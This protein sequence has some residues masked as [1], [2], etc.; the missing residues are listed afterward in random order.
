[1]G[2]ETPK[3]NFAKLT[4]TYP[5]EVS[6]VREE[7]EFKGYTV[8][9]REENGWGDPILTLNGA[10]FRYNKEKKQIQVF[11]VDDR[12]V[13]CDHARAR[14]AML[15]FDACELEYIEGAMFQWSGYLT[16]LRL[17]KADSDPYADAWP[18][19]CGSSGWG[20]HSRVDAWIPDAIR[21]IPQRMEI[22]M[23]IPL[24]SPA[25]V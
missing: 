7:G 3:N 17:H 22:S 2:L 12:Y 1:M 9:I 25:E 23:S 4:P 21:A 5:T 20:E 24:D 13:D 11:C 19:G 10:T 6:S 18:C 14:P 8:H 16:E 15:G